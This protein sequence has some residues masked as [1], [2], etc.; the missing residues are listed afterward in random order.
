MADVLSEISLALGLPGNAPVRAILDAIAELQLSA[1]L[2]Q[3]EVAS[4]LG[5]AGDAS[6]AA[7]LNAIDVLIA[8]SAQAPIP[9]LI[10]QAVGDGRI[11]AGHCTWWREKLE[12]DFESASD[13]LMGMPVGIYNRRPFGTPPEDQ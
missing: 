11:D 1:R 3:I 4:K 12:K 8:A 9:L 10:E 13:A 6:S 5:L 7:V 2:M